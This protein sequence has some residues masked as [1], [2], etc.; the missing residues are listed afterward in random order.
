MSSNE[1]RGPSARRVGL[2]TASALLV[3]PAL[4]TLAVFGSLGQAATG[5]AQPTPEQAE[6]LEKLREAHRLSPASVGKLTAIFT[7]APRM[8]TG[9]PAVTRHPLSV[10]DCRSRQAAAK[11]QTTDPEAERICGGPYMV[12][13]YDPS[14]ARPEDAQACIDMFEFPDIPCEY[15]VVWTRTSDAAAVCEAMGKRLCDAH[16][17]EGACAGELEAPDYRFDLATGVSALTAVGLMRNANNAADPQIWSYGESYREGV[18]GTGSSKSAG[19]NGG[20]WAGCGSNTYPAGSFPECRSPL[21]AYDLN[22]NAAEAMNLPL[23]MSEMA[24]RGSTTLGVTELKGSWF[25]FDQVRAHEDSCRWRAPFWHGTRV[26]D[27]ASHQNYHL[28]FRCCQTL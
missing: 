3:L 13:L 2:Q 5:G 7:A 6:L 14:K 28:G 11:M 4:L 9:N 16:E 8:G 25:V 24:S 18:C 20:E 21:G 23:S 12:P 1:Q 19:C 27:P 26:R 10:E 22:G 17:W 15:P